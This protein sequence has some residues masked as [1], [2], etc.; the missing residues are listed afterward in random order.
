LFSTLAPDN[1]WQAPAKS[2]WP[3]DAVGVV[4]PSVVYLTVAVEAQRRA[5]RA[6]VGTVS[7]VE[8]VT[9]RLCCPGPSGQ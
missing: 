6:P 8:L 2:G 9:V 1:S 7:A 3:S 4:R 5:K